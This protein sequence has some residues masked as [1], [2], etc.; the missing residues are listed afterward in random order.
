MGILDFLWPPQHHYHFGPST[1]EIEAAVRGVLGPQMEKLMADFSELKAEVAR[2]NS[3][4]Q[5][6]V[7]LL[8]GL[9]TQLEDAK[10]DPEEIAAITSELKSQTD[11]LAAA[12]ATGTPAE[13]EPT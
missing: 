12:V 13:G 2:N 11:A 8:Q 3:V 4:V 6:A 9:V 5:S 10:D 1:A 7:T